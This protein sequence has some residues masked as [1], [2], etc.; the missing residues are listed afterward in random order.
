MPGPWPTV[1]GHVL[2]KPAEIW[3]P[4]RIT[5]RY[6][7][8]YTRYGLWSSNNSR[9]HLV[10]TPCPR[11]GVGVALYQDSGGEPML[12]T[13]GASRRAAATAGTPH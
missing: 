12:V 2:T 10:E 9:Q 11:P 5:A 1:T 3:S 8:I 7:P 4:S 6:A 13:Y